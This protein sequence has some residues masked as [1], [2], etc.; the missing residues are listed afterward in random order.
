MAVLTPTEPSFLYIMYYST[1]YL[2]IKIRIKH[3]RAK[4]AHTDTLNEGLAADFF[5][6]AREATMIIAMRIFK[7]FISI[8][9]SPVKIYTFNLICRLW[10]WR[11]SEH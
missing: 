9:L 3:F 6:N 11:D 1:I 5:S 2:P 4:N 7:N 8:V 10:I